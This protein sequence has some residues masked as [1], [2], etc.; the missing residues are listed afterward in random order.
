MRSALIAAQVAFSYVLLIGAGLMVHSLIQLERVD[1]GFA[2]E[3]LF[4][5]G[6]DL[7]FT[8]YPDP[9]SRRMAAKRL[10]ERVQAIPGVTLGGRRVQLP[11]G[12]RQH[13]SWQRRRPVP[14]LW[15]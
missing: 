5:V 14:R 1:P 10:L 6:I 11:D 4:A 15:R 9:P 3:H 2:P 13:Q 12:P 8:K 7:N